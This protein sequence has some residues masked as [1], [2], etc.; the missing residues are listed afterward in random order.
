VQISIPIQT[1]PLEKITIEEVRD[2]LL[3]IQDSFFGDLIVQ[4]SMN[5]LNRIIEEKINKPYDL[6]IKAELVN[7]N[8]KLFGYDLDSKAILDPNCNI[9]FISKTRFKGK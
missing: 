7:N 8:V 3:E 9:K 5:E 1:A 4:D 2:K 6:K